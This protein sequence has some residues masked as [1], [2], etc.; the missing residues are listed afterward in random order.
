MGSCQTVPLDA[1]CWE[2]NSSSERAA[3]ALSFVW[4][5]IVP[6]RF[7]YHGFV[8]GF[9]MFIVFFFSYCS[10]II[11]FLC[12]KWAVSRV[13]RQWKDTEDR[14]WSHSQ[15]QPLSLRK[16]GICLV[17]KLSAFRGEDFRA[18]GIVIVLHKG[19]QADPL[20]FLSCA[21]GEGWARSPAISSEYCLTVL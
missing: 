2:L 14:P 16:S 3:T 10:F 6:H 4:L 5:V 9:E 8:V 12:V 7:D 20:G 18:L 15:G 11:T 1:G 21:D 17:K 19:W 13:V